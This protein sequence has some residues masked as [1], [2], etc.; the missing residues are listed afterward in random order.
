MSFSGSLGFEEQDLRDDQVGHLVVDLLAQED[1]PFP[2]QL[3]VDVEGPI[4]PA[5]LLDDGRHQNL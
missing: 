3:G 4:A 2:E 1:D 5:A